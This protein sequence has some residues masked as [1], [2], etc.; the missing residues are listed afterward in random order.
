MNYIF[1]FKII[2]DEDAEVYVFN[3][4]DMPIVAESESVEEA[5]LSAM[6]FLD[7][8]CSLNLEL[9]GV[10]DQ[11]SKYID[12]V[13]SATEGEIILLADYRSEVSESKEESLFD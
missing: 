4:V 11:A 10:I 6:S 12:V 9:N 7:A 3:F 8:Y 5:F 1:P 2:Y 13:K